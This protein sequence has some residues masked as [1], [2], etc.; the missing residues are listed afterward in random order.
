M[1]GKICT[2]V[3]NRFSKGKGQK[4]KR[5]LNSKN[6]FNNVFYTFLK[7]S[8]CIFIT[9][10]TSFSVLADFRVHKIRLVSSDIRI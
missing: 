7:Q 1:Y 8:S 4:K 5:N 9:E 10:Y 6:M 2:Y 3:R